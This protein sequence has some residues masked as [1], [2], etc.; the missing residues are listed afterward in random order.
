MSS[1]S[2]VRFIW[3]KA[4]AS[5]ADSQKNTWRTSPFLPCERS[6]THAAV[7]ESVPAAFDL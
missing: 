7:E 5:K 3:K 6:A 2:R 1:P 4:I